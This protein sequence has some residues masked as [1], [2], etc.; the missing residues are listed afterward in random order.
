MKPR[1]DRCQV[2][3][4]FENDRLVAVAASA[5]AGEV[6]V[7]GW[8]SGDRPAEVDANDAGAIGVW[9]SGQLKKAGM[10]RMARADGVI[11]A[12]PR[13]EVVLK[14]ITFPPGTSEPDLPGMVRLQ[15][16]RQLTMSPENASIDFVSIPTT[17]GPTTN[18]A[19]PRATTV[20]AAALQGDRLAW[21]RAVARAAG[22]RLGRVALKSAGAAALLAELSQRRGGG[23]LGITLGCGSTEFVVVEDG[24]MVFA[25]ATDLVRPDSVFEAEA[26]AEKVAVEAKRTWM[27]YRV[28]PDSAEIDAVMVLGV[29]VVAGRVAAKCGEALEL[30]SEASDYPAFVQTTMEMPEADRSAA[31]P[32]L[33][34]VAAPVIGREMV[35]FANPRRA[36]DLMAAKR[37]L[38]LAAALAVI[39]CGGT[40][41]T[42]AVKDLSAR[43]ADLE[44]LKDQRTK[45]GSDYEQY[46]HAQARY[47]HLKGWTDTRVDWLAHLSRLNDLMP[48]PR[49]AQL[50]EIS[51]RSQ[52]EVS[53]TLPKGKRRYVEGEWSRAVSASFNL[54][55]RMK[56]REVADALRTVLVT[57]D[58]YRLQPR[59]A[60]VA[61]RFQW[62]LTTPLLRPGK[63]GEPKAD[64]PADAKPAP[65]KAADAKGPAAKAPAKT[66]G[67]GP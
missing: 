20:L 23:I 27:S 51:G 37:R 25:R 32:L 11:F 3:L 9:I 10:L 36:P 45:D 59:G 35:D 31:A 19:Q 5:S 2:A 26:F 64:K 41:Y 56:Q 47:D 49:Q 65:V 66:K 46:V 40:G 43:R 7:K 58:Q 57:E 50:D 17:P 44:S 63:P 22:V 12:V 28:T 62:T 18:L 4:N 55:G 67:G 16:L 54:V 61:D 1:A 34:L 52:I 38:V 48:D 60:D 30:P 13:G 14:R 39:V 42:L 53:F 15:M 6:Q 21:R 33:G 8:L 24:Q 29:D